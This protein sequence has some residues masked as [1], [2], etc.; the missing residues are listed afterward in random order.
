MIGDETN[1][2]AYQNSVRYFQIASLKQQACAILFSYRVQNYT[3]FLNCASL[4]LDTKGFLMFFRDA[5][6]LK[7]ND[8]TTIHGDI[9]EIL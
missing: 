4:G 3:K 9:T 1:S 2:Y 8:I 6:S 5:N 7:I